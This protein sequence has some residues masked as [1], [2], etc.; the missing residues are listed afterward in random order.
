MKDYLMSSSLC[1]VRME[2]ED[3]GSS[4]SNL[5]YARKML[6]RGGFTRVEQRQVLGAAG[7]AWGASAIQ[8][9]LTIMYG[10]TSG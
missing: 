2:K 9:A 7:A 1:Q 4:V 3:P 10:S 8:A 5:S 6:R